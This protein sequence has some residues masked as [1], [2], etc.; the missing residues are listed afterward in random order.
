M[1]AEGQFPARHLPKLKNYRM[2]Q[3]DKRIQKD[4]KK[5]IRILKNKF[6]HNLRAVILYGSWIKGKAREDSDIDLLIIFN[7]KRKNLIKKVYSL[8]WQMNLKRDISLASASIKEF[9]KE[10]MPFYT[11]IKREGQI[12]YGKVDLGLHL[13]PPHVKYRDFFK[14]S[15]DYEKQKL[16]TAEYL[17]KRGISLGISE[18]CCI[19]AKHAIQAGLAMKGIGFSSKFCELINWTEKYFGKKLADDFKT[20]FELYVKS[21]Y[22]LQDLNRRE[23]LLAIKVAKRILR[24]IYS[25]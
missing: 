25:I 4:L 6:K 16:R 21:E 22:N 9:K 15:A 24:K 1:V 2:P 10:T 13:K 17:I 14:R 20:I 23:N 18:H 5:A 11:A 8:I 12:I 7:T 3:I 19:A